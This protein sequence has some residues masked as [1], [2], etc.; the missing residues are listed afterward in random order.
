MANAKLD[1]LQNTIDPSETDSF[2]AW[3]FFVPSFRENEGSNWNRSQR[4]QQKSPDKA[5]P[6]TKAFN[7]ADTM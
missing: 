4:L 7:Y 5:V 1:G 6:P 2:D 3:C